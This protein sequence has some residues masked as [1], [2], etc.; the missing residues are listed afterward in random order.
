MNACSNR[1]V[2]KGPVFHSL[3]AATRVS[4]VGFAAGVARLF[5]VRGS[6]KV[7]P[8]AANQSGTLL[9]FGLFGRDPAKPK[10]P[11]FIA[12]FFASSIPAKAI[13]VFRMAF[14]Q[15]LSCG[16]AFKVF[17]PVIRLVSVDVVNLFSLI[18]VSHPAVRYS[19]VDKVFTSY[20]R[21][22]QWMGCR[23]IRPVLSKDFPAA[24]NSVK[25]VKHTV[26]N[27]VHRKVDHVVPPRLVTGIIF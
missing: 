27:A 13:N 25:M 18:K 15:V 11:D 21:I 4:D 5:G 7:R 8:F 16:K 24:R 19:S 20:T 6:R 14:Q 23:R 17:Q 26:F 3:H 22:A 1:R 2:S 10:L 9:C 12:G